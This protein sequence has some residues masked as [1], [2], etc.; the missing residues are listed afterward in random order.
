MGSPTCLNDPAALV[1]LDASAAINLCAAGCAAEM[2][3]ALPNRALVV[4][5]IPAELEEGRRRGRR[6]A[7]LLGDLVA[8]RLIEIVALGNPAEAIF[9]SLV[10][11]SAAQTLDD[12]EA[13]TI[14]YAAGHGAIAIIDERKAIRICGA[15]FPALRLGCTV[16]LLS[17]PEVMRVLGRDRVSQAVLNALQLARMRVLPHHIGWVIELIGEKQAALCASLPRSTRTPAA[18]VA[19]QNS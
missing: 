7:D 13:A 17:H 14:A 12:G 3:R 18:S 2:L 6:D 4:D 11:G 15:R 16:D 10:V 19:G 1:V 5:A 8:A 9:E